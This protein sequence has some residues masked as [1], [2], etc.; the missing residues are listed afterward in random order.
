MSGASVQ[1]KMKKLECEVCKHPLPN[2]LKVDGH[3]VDTIDITRPDCPYIIFDCKS[4]KKGEMGLFLVHFFNEEVIKIGRG[5]G[6]DIR[7]SDISLSRHHASLL[8]DGNKF[9]IFDNNSKF[10]TLSL[11]RNPLE[12][13]A[14]KVA[15][16]IG[17]TVI[18]LFYKAPPAPKPN[19]LQ[20]SLTKVNKSNENFRVRNVNGLSRKDKKRNTISNPYMTRTYFN[21]QP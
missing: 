2:K 15:V 14:E 5:H 17:R 7:V 12:I 18:S 9:L 3:P 10:G 21:N 6:N 8:M 20:R 4:H 13:F 1:F 16:Q 19:N 11:I